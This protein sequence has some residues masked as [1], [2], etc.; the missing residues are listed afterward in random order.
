MLLLNARAS[1]RFNLWIAG[2]VVDAVRFP[3]TDLLNFLS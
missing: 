2:H 1:G 3:L